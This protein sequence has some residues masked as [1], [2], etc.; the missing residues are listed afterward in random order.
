MSTCAHTH[1]P[2]ENQGYGEVKQICDT[3]LGVQ[4]Q[5][6]VAQ[7]INLMRP[8][9]KLKGRLGGVALKVNMKLNGDNATIAGQP[10][11]WCP[12]LAR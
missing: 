9:D 1:T 8:D 7:N 3:V 12:V 10:S 5:V 11:D 4:S 6:L 2:A